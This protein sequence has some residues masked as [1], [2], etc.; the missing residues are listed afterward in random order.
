L[1]RLVEFVEWSNGKNIGL[2]SMCHLKMLTVIG[3]ICT[4]SNVLVIPWP[5]S[6][7]IITLKYIDLFNQLCLKNT[8]PNRRNE[9]HFLFQANLRHLWP[10]SHCRRF[11]KSVRSE[12]RI[13]TVESICF[14]YINVI[15]TER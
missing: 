3:T 8:W 1:R 15:N 11:C 5:N 14:Q 6:C 9:E 2:C 7:V 10:L 12:I 4:R 13:H